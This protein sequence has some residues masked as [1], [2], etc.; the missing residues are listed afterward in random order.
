MAKLPL[1]EQQ[2]SMGQVRASGQQF[3]S[4]VAQAVG[5]VG[6]VV[7]DLGVQMKRRQDVIERVQLMTEFDKFAQDALTA[8]ND[9]EDISNPATVSKYEQGLREK[10]GEIVKRHGGT[11]G[12]R[13]ELQA[14]IENQVGQYAKSA[15]ATQ[16]KAQ[17]A[18]I[19]SRID[20]KA[21]ELAISGA[22]APDK[23]PELFASL[24]AD[25]DMMSDALSPTVAAQYKE[26]GRSRIATAT[27]SQLLQ[28][29]EFNQAQALLQNP[30][31]GRY[32]QPD[33]ART[34]A[35]NITVDQR[36]AELEAERQNKNVASWAQ[37]LGRDLTPQEVIKVRSMPEKKDMTVADQIVE[38]ELITGKPAP[39]SVIDQFYKVDGPA[40]G[41]GSMFGN[42]LQGRALSYVTENA[43]AY[44]N[45]MLTADQAR[46][47]EASLAEAYKPV[48]RQNPST[49]L[50]EE[51]RPTIPNF[52]TQAAQQGSRIY[53]GT[54]LT[55]SR[56][57]GGA[58]MPGQS[59]M[60]T[61]PDGRQVGPG[62]V[63]P[64]GTWSITDTAAPAAAPTPTPQA[65]G[66]PAVPTG[67]RTIW[68]RRRSIAG[69]IAA[70]T[71]GVSRIPGV[72]PQIAGAVMG[73]AETREMEADRTFVENASRDLIRILQNNP[74]FA[75]GERQAIEKE[76]SIGPEV[77]RSQKSYE[78]KLIGVAQSLSE[79]KRDAQAALAGEIS[80]EERKR[81]MDNIQAIDSFMRK[82]GLPIVV[83]TEEQAASLPPGTVFMDAKGNEYRKR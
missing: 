42:S 33:T 68:E 13:A 29:G 76:I 74:R 30:E 63:G 52:V 9:T 12:S 55:A 5:Q 81:N 7:A 10:A 20:Q 43:V 83:T 44:A 59:V 2:T 49:G 80:L 17:Q 18:F 51:V 26:A 78:A 28:R 69:P 61:L 72:G 77:F 34:F 82:L 66:A 14:Q 32:L 75:E 73:E 11:M 53:G 58:P 19:A 67:E 57:Q 54:S 70:A 40:G 6:E 37:R 50:L 4:G 22:F 64:D 56:A 47:Y 79:R 35:I 62:R 21:S 31:V 36:K 45:G 27:I 41:G 46:T 65:S 71:A 3:G 25:I 38:Y 15:T 16:V 24:D 48:M 39:Q 23:M 60:L 1:Y 8:I